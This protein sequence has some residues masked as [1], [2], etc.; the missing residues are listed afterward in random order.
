MIWIAAATQHSILRT[1]RYPPKCQLDIFSEISICSF[2]TV[3]LCAC[4]YTRWKNIAWLAD[5][6][7]Y[8][9]FYPILTSKSLFNKA[10][11]TYETMESNT[12]RNFSMNRQDELQVALV[13]VGIVALLLL[14][15]IFI[16]KW[17][18]ITYCFQKL[19]S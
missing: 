5:A 7:I 14:T 1:Q 4:T 2:S 18:S 17:D 15:L 13:A 12:K 6:A 10:I 3:F 8:F 11:H 19:V 9:Q 16:L